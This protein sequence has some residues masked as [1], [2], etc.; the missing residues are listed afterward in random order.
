LAA[1]APLKLVPTAI[2]TAMT[3]PAIIV[4]EIL[5]NGFIILP[6]TINE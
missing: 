1:L 2:M 5:S 6:L 4:P 3:K